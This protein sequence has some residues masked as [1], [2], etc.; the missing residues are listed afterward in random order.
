MKIQLI[1]GYLLALLLLSSCQ[2]EGNLTSECSIGMITAEV[3]VC[4][5]S[6]NYPLV[7]DFDSENPNNVFFDLKL[8]DSVV[9]GTFPLDQLPLS[10]ENFPPSGLSNDYIQICINGNPDCCAEIEFVSPA[11][12]TLETCPVVENVLIEA[13]DCTTASAYN[14]SINFEHDFDS[15]DVVYL[16]TRNHEQTYIKYLDELPFQLSGFPLSGSQNDYLK[17][18]IADSINCCFE[19]EW[20]PPNCADEY[21]CL[22]EDLTAQIGDCTADGN[23]SV[24]VDFQYDNPSNEFFDLYTREDSLIASYRLNDLPLTLTDFSPSGLE[25]DFIKVCIN[26]NPDCCEAIEFMPPA[27]TAVC[28]ISNLTASVG[29]CNSTSNYALSID[30]NYENAAN[31]SFDLYVRD[32][33]LIGNYSLADLPLTI[34]DFP[35]SGNTDDY[36]RVCINDNSNCCAVLEFESPNCGTN[37]ACDLRDLTVEH[38]TCQDSTYNMTFDFIYENT[39]SEYFE[40]YTADA[41]PYGPFPLA[42]LP[43]TFDGFVASGNPKDYI[44]V[45]IDNNPSCC[46]DV[47]WDSPCN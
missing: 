33:Q 5:D 23:Y 9:F 14:L 7:L 22:V 10:I 35:L 41:G 20:L 26:D 13:S 8:R 3:G 15:N 1:F 38:T 44:R 28:S 16:I 24:M 45:C 18:C 19:R 37:S 42:D 21:P 4:N 17:I 11:C 34:Q 31:G 32:D 2:G 40:V 29:A 39:G 43:F 46:T 47:E 25:Y 30:F 27:C 12:E 36:I 6:G